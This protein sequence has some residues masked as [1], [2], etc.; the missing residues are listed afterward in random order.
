MKVLANGGLNLSEL[1]GWW[2]EAYS[3]QVGWALGDGREHG[4]DP[5]WDAAEAA[6]LYD[7]LEKEVSPT[8]YARNDGNLPTD[9]LAK[10]RASMTTLT[11]RFSANRAVHQYTNEYYLPAAAAYEARRANQSA[12]GIRL[13]NWRRMM[14]KEWNSMSFG[15][16]QVETRNGQ[17]H[18]RVEVIFGGVDPQA[19]QV[20]LCAAGP[21]DRVRRQPMARGGALP[22]RKG[23]YL[24]TAQ[25]PATQPAGDFTPRL[26]PYFPGVAVPLEIPLIL[27]QH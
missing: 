4:D 3:P 20:E 26:I 13:T 15:D 23:G 14:A 16:L 22:D 11:A 27:W 19:V 25:V 2:A 12:L 7:T 24:F 17:H 8:F 5:G 1:D 10:V 21:E 9:W 6:A 18:F